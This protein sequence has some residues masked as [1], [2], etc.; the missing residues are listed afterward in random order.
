MTTTVPNINELA[1]SVSNALKQSISTLEAYQKN[2]TTP[3]VVTRIEGRLRQLRRAADRLI[4][5]RK[6][7]NLELAGARRAIV[8]AVGAGLLVVYSSDPVTATAK[9]KSMKTNVTR[10]RKKQSPRKRKAS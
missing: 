4:D 5:S 2:E 10:E 1:D 3:W 7:A 8:N 6:H 9:F